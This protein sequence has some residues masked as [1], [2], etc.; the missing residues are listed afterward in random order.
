MTSG[1]SMD[2][3]WEPGAEISVRTE[4]NTVLISANAPGL[5]SLAGILKTLAK[6]KMGDHVHLDRYNSLEEGSA[7]LILEK[8]DL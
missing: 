1:G 7:E 2:I 5:I 8:T 4:E 3:H 6:G